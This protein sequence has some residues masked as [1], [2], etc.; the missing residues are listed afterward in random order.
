MLGYKSL[1]TFLFGR[2]VD[3]YEDTFAVVKVNLPK[4]DIKIPFRTYMSTVI[5]SSIIVAFLTL[6]PLYIV[7]SILNLS[8]MMRIILMIFIPILTAMCC[9]VTLSFYPYH[10]AT[11]RSKNI[12]NNL[13][14]VLTHMGAVAESGVPPYVIFKLIAEFEEYG[15]VS[16]EMKKIVRNIETFGIDPL[17]A[18][19]EVAERS[20][21]EQVCS[22]LH[23]FS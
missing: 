16:K 20:P 7:L 22:S 1:A 17:T 19:K 3:A 12:E 6:I 14:F 15:E 11:S 4:A 9:F 2:L 21:S 18:V 5:L 13:P 8:F 10:K 23:R